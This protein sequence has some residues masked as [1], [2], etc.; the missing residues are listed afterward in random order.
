MVS[1]NCVAVSM[2]WSV[3]LVL[4]LPVPSFPFQ[5]CPVTKAVTSGGRSSVHAPIEK[6]VEE[7]SGPST[8][9]GG[10]AGSGISASNGMTSCEWPPIE[11]SGSELP[12]LTALQALTIVRL[13][14][15]IEPLSCPLLSGVCFSHGS[16]SVGWNFLSS[17]TLCQKLRIKTKWRLHKWARD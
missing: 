4:Y 16:A 7:V 11:K 1:P 15:Y 2:S 3:P 10:G 5:P 6:Q 12:R 13:W 9:P 8:L 17:S 14:H